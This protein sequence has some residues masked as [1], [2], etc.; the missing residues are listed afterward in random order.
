MPITPEKLKEKFKREGKT[1]KDFA[2][3]NGYPY[4]EV[5]RVVNGINKARRGRGHE[6]AV[7]LG[8]KDGSMQ[9]TA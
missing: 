6:I 8:L 4:N 9:V 2:T 7:K 3:A 5:V 1:F